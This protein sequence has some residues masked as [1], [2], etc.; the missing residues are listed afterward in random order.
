[1]VNDD[2]E[3]KL[4]IEHMVNNGISGAGTPPN[5]REGVAKYVI[6]AGQITKV[7]M[8]EGTTGTFDD[9]S[10]LKVWGSN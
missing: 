7:S 2:G 4:V 10:F 1:V 6:T 5:R 8:L 3:E 9:K